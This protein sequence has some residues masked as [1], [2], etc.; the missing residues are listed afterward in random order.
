M[1]PAHRICDARL[2]SRCDLSRHLRTFRSDGDLTSAGRRRGAEVSQPRLPDMEDSVFNV[3]YGRDD[4]PC[5]NADSGDYSNRASDQ[6]QFDSGH[7]F[8]FRV[9]E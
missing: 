6:D 1:R 9:D 5:A 7:S 3:M 2:R 4:P 8:F